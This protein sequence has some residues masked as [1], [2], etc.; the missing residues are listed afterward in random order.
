MKGVLTLFNQ[1]YWNIKNKWFTCSFLSKGW[2]DPEE[3]DPDPGVVEETQPCRR[4]KSWP[5]I[6]SLS[7]FD[8]DFESADS[9]QRLCLLKNFASL[10]IAGYLAELLKSPHFDYLLNHHHPTGHLRIL[11]INQKVLL[12]RYCPPHLH[13]INQN[14]LLFTSC[15]QYQFFYYYLSSIKNNY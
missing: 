15:L 10:A 3:V 2:R 5:Q 13:F 7:G 8:W 6:L 1:I 14:K 4:P 11:S 12:P 9:D